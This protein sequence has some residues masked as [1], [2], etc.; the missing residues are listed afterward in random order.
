MAW[1]Q[2]FWRTVSLQPQACCGKGPCYHFLTI[3]WGIF[4]LANPTHKG[5]GW[6]SA[7]AATLLPLLP[8]QLCV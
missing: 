5:Q 1:A 4:A 8:S 6:A 7:R 3:P 2:K